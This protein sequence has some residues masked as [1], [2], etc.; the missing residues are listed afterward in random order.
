M[1]S[2]ASH[3][4]DKDISRI[5]RGKTEQSEGERDRELLLDSALDVQ[6]VI[7]KETRRKRSSREGRDYARSLRAILLALTRRTAKG[8][9]NVRNGVLASPLRKLVTQRVT[10]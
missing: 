2:T 1:I 9:D 10:Q 4:G 5:D 3:S 7:S 6:D 8:K